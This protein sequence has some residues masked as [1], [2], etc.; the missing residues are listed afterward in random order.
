[1]LLF[2]FLRRRN[3]LSTFFVKAF[4][5]SRDSLIFTVYGKSNQNIQERKRLSKSDNA[6]NN[7]QYLLS[8]E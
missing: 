8:D 1:V 3:Y 4:L 7:Q 5:A 6:Q 2:N